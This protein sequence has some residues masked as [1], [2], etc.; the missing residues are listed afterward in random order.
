MLQALW[1]LGR[2][3]GEDSKAELAL[4]RELWSRGI[5]YR[6]HYPGLSGRPDLVFLSARLTVFVDGDFWH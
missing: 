5:R 6:L 2:E 1:E 3:G 4:R